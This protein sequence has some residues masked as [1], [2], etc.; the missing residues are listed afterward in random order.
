MRIR[1][2]FCLKRAVCSSAR[3][4]CIRFKPP[5]CYLFISIKLYTD[6]KS[7]KNRAVS[8]WKEKTKTKNLLS[9]YISIYIYNI[10]TCIYIYV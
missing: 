6:L 10:Y 4:S 7:E 5:F 8:F 2:P 3:E 1:A 9:I